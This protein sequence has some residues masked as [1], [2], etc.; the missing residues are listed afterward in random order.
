[1][2]NPWSTRLN[3]LSEPFRFLT[4]I[5]V[6][7]C[8]FMLNSLTVQQKELTSEIRLHVQDPNLHYAAVG[9]FT[10]QMKGVITRVEAAERKLDVRR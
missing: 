10:E 6:T 9:R 2:N 1:M 3:G 5:L 7:I 8:L 4:P